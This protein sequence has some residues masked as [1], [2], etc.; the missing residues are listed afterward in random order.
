MKTI[1]IFFILFGLNLLAEAKNFSSYFKMV[2][3]IRLDPGKEI[4]S[5]FYPF[6]VDS[7]GNI[8][9]C[10]YR[11]GK[12]LLFDNDGHFLKFIAKS[13][14]GP[15]EVL[16]PFAGGMGID[17]Q[18]VIIDDAA[19]RVSFFDKEKKFVSSFFLNSITQPGGLAVISRNIIYMPT[20]V[21]HKKKDGNVSIDYIAKYDINGTFIKSF[22]P[23]NKRLDGL[24]NTSRSKMLIIQNRIFAVQ[25]H[26][27]SISVLDTSGIEIKKFGKKPNYFVEQTDIRLT[28]A[29]LNHK[30]IKAK[31][32]LFKE[33]NE[34][35]T[36]IV[37]FFA[38]DEMLFITSN[39]FH[40]EI[41]ERMDKIEI[42]SLEGE[43]I[44]GN[45]DC[46]KMFFSTVG[47][48]GFTYFVIGKEI[49]DMN[50]YYLLGK[51]KYIGPHL[52]NH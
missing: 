37:G 45:I 51:F 19:R 49:E 5:H 2:K 36:P 33:L 9:A 13:G 10:D 42:Y 44:D 26:I 15:G 14:R 4:I 47:N 43:H 17:D 27:F 32:K 28:E 20:K 8:I 31:R 25:T 12:V 50:T 22:F 11:I 7:K 29:E 46:N 48:D 41:D 35:L 34:I 6:F 30:R 23:V 24:V 1:L 38:I 18:L 3:T 16:Q 39:V 21:F 52:Q 40:G